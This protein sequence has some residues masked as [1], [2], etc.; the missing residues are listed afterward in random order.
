MR[1]VKQWTGGPE[2]VLWGS[3]IPSRHLL[4]AVKSQSG[5][6]QKVHEMTRL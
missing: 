3:L 1:T 4:Q 6:D 5:M 2:R